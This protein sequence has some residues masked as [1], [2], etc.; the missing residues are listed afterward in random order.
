M[1]FKELD[2]VVLADGTAGYL[3]EDFGDDHYLFEYKTIDGAHEYDDKIIKLEDI[4][5]YAESRGGRQRTSSKN[6]VLLRQVS[7]DTGG[8]HGV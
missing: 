4:A 6:D 7:A 3:L 2:H 1:R 8:E 5:G